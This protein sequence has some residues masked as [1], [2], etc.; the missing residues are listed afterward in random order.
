[1]PREKAPDWE[2]ASIW[3]PPHLASG[4][5]TGGCV[6]N[7]EIITRAMHALI[8]RATPGVFTGG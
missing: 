8:F 3:R 4:E 2:K 7:P 6:V 5:Y 1:M